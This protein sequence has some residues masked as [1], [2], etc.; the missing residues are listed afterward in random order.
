MGIAHPA[1]PGGQL[2]EEFG[3]IGVPP[4]RDVPPG[5]EHGA[6]A[7]DAGEVAQLAQLD[8]GMVDAEA[9]RHQ[10]GGDPLRGAVPAY[11][12]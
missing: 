5:G 1:E 7:V 3:P 10:P 4:R 11:L 12:L 9:D 8:D 6:G 2:Y